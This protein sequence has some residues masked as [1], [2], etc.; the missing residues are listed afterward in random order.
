MPFIPVKFLSLQ[1]LI[2]G[3]SNTEKGLLNRVVLLDLRKAFNIV[4]NDVLLHKLSLY[5]CDDLT[6]NWFK[7]YLKDREQC[8]IFKE[9]LTKPNTVTNG[10]HQGSILGPL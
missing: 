10:V 8:V 9:N 3:T 5:Q 6:I 4:D 7:S 1:L 2:K